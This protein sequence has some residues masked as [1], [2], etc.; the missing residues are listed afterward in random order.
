MQYSL[1]DLAERFAC[2]LHGDGDILISSACTLQHGKAGAITFLSNPK[3]RKYLATTKAAAVILRQQDA[4]LSPAAA[5]IHA[6]PYACYARIA[7]LLSSHPREHESGVHET[8]IVDTAASL[9][10]DVTVGP[11]AVIDANAVIGD[12]VYIGPGCV[13]SR[14]VKIAA[15]SFL[16]SNITI[17]HGCRI[18]Q[19]ALIHAG[20]IIGADG[21]GIAQ[22]DGKWVKV[23]Q[24]G[25]VMI[26]DD[27]EIGASTSIDRGAIEDTIIED[28][29]KLDNQIQIGHNV[30][31][32][33]HTAIAGCVGVAGS[34]DIGQR[35][36]IAAMTLVLGHI[37]LADDV[38]ITAQS[39]VTRSIPEPGVYSSGTPLQKNAQ[40][41]RNFTRFGQLDV[42]AK[43]LSEIEKHLQ[44]KS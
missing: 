22:D 41:K 16:H 24:L 32:G 27:V 7:Q 39:M 29:V 12:G 17:Y 4:A 21:F 42:L 28:G 1:F 2:E 8:A 44:D 6:N 20:V 14:D 23:P 18:G 40:W 3:Y 9:G 43:R 35:C 5:L 10:K 19:R 36:T 34:A 30:R 25:G 31:L 26:G 37:K 11:L 38:H 13:I 15:N 33:A